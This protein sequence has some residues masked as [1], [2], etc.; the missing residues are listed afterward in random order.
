[1][2]FLGTADASCQT[3]F[4]VVITNLFP[5]PLEPIFG[6]PGAY[7]S[8]HVPPQIFGFPYNTVIDCQVS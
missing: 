8:A 6:P 5:P 7:L 4:S 1:M 3:C 2:E